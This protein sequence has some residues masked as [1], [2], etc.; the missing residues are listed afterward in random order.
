MNTTKYTIGLDLG[1]KR[2]EVHV[3]NADGETATKQSIVNNRES[4][5]KLAKTYPRATIIME[6]GTHSPWISRHLSTRA[7]NVLIANPRKVR[8]IYQSENKSD[9]RDAEMLARIGRFDPKM[10]YPVSHNSEECQRAMAKLKARDAI[11]ANRT[12]L[13]NT[14]R[15]LLKSHG[16]KL[17]SSINAD[18][19]A[20]KATDILEKTDLFMVTDMLESIAEFTMRIKRMD[21]EIKKITADHYPQAL[22]LQ[23]IPG[24]G[25]ITALAFVLTIEDPKRFKDPRQVAPFLGLTPKRDQSGN[26]DKQ[27]RISKMGNKML[28]RLLVSCS[29][30]I[31]GVFGPP[32][33]LRNAGLRIARSG[34]KTAKKKAVVA[35]ARKLAVLMVA[36]WRDHTMAYQPFP[37]VQKNAAN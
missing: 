37:A 7:M 33:A 19:F 23:E 13:I 15:G 21:K 14:T 36:L 27:L 5:D 31:L 26:S 20:R 1:D 16:T 18:A 3:L 10:L 22:R 4:L 8:A 25:P 29:Q 6:A 12:K 30:Y 32:S 9:E 35:I 34:N 28:R 2:H 11:V 17:P 24:V